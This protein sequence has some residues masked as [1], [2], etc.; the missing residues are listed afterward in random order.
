MC[1]KY[2]YIKLISPLEVNIRTR[3]TKFPGSEHQKKRAILFHIGIK[4]C[5]KL[6]NAID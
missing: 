2:G 6:K 5:T 4:A 3:E 1:M